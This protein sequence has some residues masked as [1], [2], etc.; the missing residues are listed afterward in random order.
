MELPQSTINERFKTIAEICYKGNVTAMAKSTFV[1]R[2]T[3]VTIMADDS[4]PSYDVIRKIAEL[5][6]PRIS[7]EWLIRGTGDML[8]EETAGVTVRD[9][10]HTIVGSNNAGGMSEDFVKALL[11][12]K[13]KQIAR[14]LAII[15]NT[16]K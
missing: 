15:E 10:Q 9:T 4:Q 5:S 12:E 7:M 13:D 1:K 3:L 16:T 8:L 2:T 11:D 6:T 14:L